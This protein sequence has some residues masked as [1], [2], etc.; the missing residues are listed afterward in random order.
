MADAGF[1]EG[2]ATSS[3]AIIGASADPTKYGNKAV[4][5]YHKAGYR[6]YPINP[7]AAEVAGLQAYASVLEVPGEIETASMYV[8][9]TV[10]LMVAEQ[11]AEK[12]IKEVFMNPGSESPELVAKL[13]GLGL[14]VTQACSILAVGT[15]PEDV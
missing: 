7:N 8:P 11:L 9:P 14:K 3:I 10:G 1:R 2:P 13:K 5:A 15:S 6:V 4:R 12:G